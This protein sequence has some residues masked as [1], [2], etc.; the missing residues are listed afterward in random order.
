MFLTS[1]KKP[2]VETYHKHPKLNVNASNLE[3][4]HN[5]TLKVA[6]KED[7]TTLPINEE[8]PSSKKNEESSKPETKKHSAEFPT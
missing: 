1:T 5:R 3:F 7:A 6:T 4:E 2:E 8:A